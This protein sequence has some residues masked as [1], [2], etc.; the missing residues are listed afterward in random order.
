MKTVADVRN[1]LKQFGCVIYT[2]DSLGDLDLML[3]ELKELR[4]MGMIEKDVFLAAYRVLK[5][6]G[7]GRFADG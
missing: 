7:A 1:L 6:A 2:G 5:G 3:D 4:D